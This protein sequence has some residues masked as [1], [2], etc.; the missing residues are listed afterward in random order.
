MNESLASSII[1][2]FSLPLQEQ[3]EIYEKTV[4][5]V[6]TSAK[7]LANSL[8]SGRASGSPSWQIKGWQW[9]YLW[10]IGCLAGIYNDLYVLQFPAFRVGAIGSYRIIIFIMILDSRF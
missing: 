2:S 6:A 3:D 10:E 8:S 9:I 1:L 4:A 5:S 7:A